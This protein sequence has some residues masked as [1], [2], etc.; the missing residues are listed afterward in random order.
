M[1]SCHIVLAKPDF[2]VNTG[3]AYGLFDTNGKTHNADQLG[4]LT[5]VQNRDLPAI[6]GRLENVFEQFVEVPGRI[7]MKEVLRASGAAGVCMSGSGPTLLAFSLTKHRRWQRHKIWYLCQGYSRHQ[8]GA[9]WL[10]NCRSHRGLIE[11]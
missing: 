1:P 3:K 7:E 6:C 4:M 2:G 10:Q 9:A 5:A 11:R 8:A